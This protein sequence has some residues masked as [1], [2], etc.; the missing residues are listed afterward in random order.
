[1]FIMFSLILHQSLDLIASVYE[2]IELT[3]DR[4]SEAI[5]P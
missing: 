2:I 5:G 1:M 3:F 4:E